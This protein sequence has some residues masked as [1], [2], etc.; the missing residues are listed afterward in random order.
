MFP[1]HKASWCT[2]HSVLSLSAPYVS[3]HVIF[4][5][6]S[7]VR[8]YV[9]NQQLHLRT[10]FQEANNVFFQDEEDEQAANAAAAE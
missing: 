2:L 9:G 6:C 8:L 3:S 10:C 1:P 4:S 7:S 5:S